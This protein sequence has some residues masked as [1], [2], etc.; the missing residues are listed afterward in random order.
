MSSDALFWPPCPVCG[1]AWRAT[2]RRMLLGPVFFAAK[3]WCYLPPRLLAVVAA[4]WDGPLERDELARR[5]G[6]GT[7]SRTARKAVNDA[8]LVLARK[9]WGARRM[10]GRVGLVEDLS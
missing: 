3:G 8:N 10:G 6:Y 1:Q 4:L 5:A 7:W 9:A 2:E